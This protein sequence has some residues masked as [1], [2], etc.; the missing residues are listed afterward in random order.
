[1]RGLPPFL[2]PPSLGICKSAPLCLG[3]VYSLLSAGWA[4]HLNRYQCWDCLDLAALDH[5][6]G[7]KYML[8]F[9]YL[10]T[11]CTKFNSELIDYFIFIFT[12]HN[13]FYIHRARWRDSLNI[14]CCSAAVA[15]GPI[16][17]VS[18]VWGLAQCRDA[19]AAADTVCHIWGILHVAAF[20]SG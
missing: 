2:S 13:I 20:K 5:E 1:M 9:L 7:G 12:I 10:L 4:S 17:A 19:Q 16:D 14:V 15:P 6:A 11:V 8:S 18:E 3:P